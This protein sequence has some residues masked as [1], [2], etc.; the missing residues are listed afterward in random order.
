M[1]ITGKPLGPF[2]VYYC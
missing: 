2:E 1:T